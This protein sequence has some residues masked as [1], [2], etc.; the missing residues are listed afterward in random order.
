MELGFLCFKQGYMIYG[1][2]DQADC[3]LQPSGGAQHF[4]ALFL[5]V[6]M[7]ALHSTSW[8]CFWQCIWPQ[9]SN[10]ASPSVT[11]ATQCI[12][13]YLYKTYGSII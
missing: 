11:S 12:I 4:L 2:P 5:A 7:A 9:L 8:Y 6:H 1:G 13:V 10:F 3:T